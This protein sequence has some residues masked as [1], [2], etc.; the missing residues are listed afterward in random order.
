MECDERKKSLQSINFYQQQYPLSTL[1]LWITKIKI[2][3]ALTFFS[4][5]NMIAKKVKFNFFPL[6]FLVFLLANSA[7]RPYDIEGELREVDSL[8]TLVKEADN[9][10]IIDENAIQNRLDSMSIKEKFINQHIEKMN[11]EVGMEFKSLMTRYEAVMKNYQKF[12]ED[13]GLVQF[14]NSALKKQ[15]NAIKDEV[16]K[17]KMSKQEFRKIY[18]NEKTKIKKHL[19]KVKKVVGSVTYIEGMYNRT[20]KKV[21]KI[22][23][24][25]KKGDEINLQKLN[26]DN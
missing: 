18:E 6:L 3:F 23:R 19:S 13:Y 8:L 4:F 7:C 20:N 12:L 22:Y 14:E 9:T 5:S 17:R 10:M 26:S 2:L 1:G 16:A 11:L 25:M 24:K 21:S 15:L